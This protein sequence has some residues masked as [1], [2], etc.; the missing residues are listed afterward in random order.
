MKQIIQLISLIVVAMVVGCER[1]SCSLHGPDT[2]A[3]NP[4]VEEAKK[5][6][7]WSGQPSGASQRMGTFS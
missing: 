2:V 3:Q 6:I 5:N 4:K 1:E 7:S